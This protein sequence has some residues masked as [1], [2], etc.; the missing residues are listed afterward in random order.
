MKLLM[1]QATKHGELVG[2]R[3]AA[4]LHKA[5]RIAYGYPGNVRISEL[6]ISTRP[7]KVRAVHQMNTGAS[8]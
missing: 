4:T 5:Y 3:Y 7:K 1:I 6:R 8:Q 2:R